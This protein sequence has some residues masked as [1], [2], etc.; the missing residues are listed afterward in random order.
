ML[1][2]ALQETL[3]NLIH[4]S[5]VT[6]ARGQIVRNP[7]ISDLYVQK[8]NALTSTAEVRSTQLWRKIDAVYRTF[9]RLQTGIS[10][11]STSSNLANAPLAYLYQ[12]YIAC[13]FIFLFTAYEQNESFRERIKGGRL[14]QNFAR[15]QELAQVVR[16]A[17]QI[18]RLEDC[19]RYDHLSSEAVDIEAELRQYD[20]PIACWVKDQD[21]SALRIFEFAPIF[22][23][24]THQSALGG[25]Q[26]PRRFNRGKTSPDQNADV[27]AENPTKNKSE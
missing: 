11:S 12:N 1:T 19:I 8:A 21:L 18:R 9:V 7:Q 20:V 24:L 13:S 27:T 26:T 22:R 3:H 25:T 10:Q 15:V 16:E 14:A 5:Q 23:A 4:I 6:D 17:R 2:D